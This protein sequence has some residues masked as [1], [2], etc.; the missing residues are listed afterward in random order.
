M[1][2]DQVEP[3]ANDI[4][5]GNSQK[6]HLK[7]KCTGMVVSLAKVYCAPTITKVKAIKDRGKQN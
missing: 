3:D 7:E 1:F 5:W 2:K 4:Y 6:V